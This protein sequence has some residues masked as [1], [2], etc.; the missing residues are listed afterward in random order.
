MY[1]LYSSRSRTHVCI[2]SQV[3]WLI[4]PSGEADRV[5]KRF[6]DFKHTLM[7][8]LYNVARETHR[9]GVPMLR[10]L[11]VEFPEDPSVWT[12]DTQYMLGPDL[13]VAPIFTED[14]A[15]RYYVPRGDWYGLLDVVIRTGPAWITERHDFFSMP[16]LLRPGRA[17]VRALA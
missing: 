7:P 16:V 10:P 15:V 11:F 4:D 13:L 8:Y 6:M 17:I 9:T 2:L 1:V 3:P 5:L 14:E 12:L